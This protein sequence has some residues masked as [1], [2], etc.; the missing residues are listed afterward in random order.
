M[1]LVLRIGLF[2]ISIK[3][4]LRASEL[5]IVEPLEKF[6]AKEAKKLRKKDRR[7]SIKEMSATMTEQ[8]PLIGKEIENDPALI[9]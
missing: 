4:L 6:E 5:L 8:A 7:E 1:T 2:L 3:E 9:K